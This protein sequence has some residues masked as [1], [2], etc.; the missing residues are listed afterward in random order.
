MRVSVNEQECE[1]ECERASKSVR[2][3]VSLNERASKSVRV[4]V[5]ECDSERVS[6]IWWNSTSVC[7]VSLS[8]DYAVSPRFCFCL[9]SLNLLSQRWFVIFFSLL[10]LC[11][12]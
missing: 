10:L 3:R 8:E 2:V 12:R 4:R 1:S 7:L 11:L 9:S 6:F 5:S